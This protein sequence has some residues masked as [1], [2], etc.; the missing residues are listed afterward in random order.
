MSTLL[1]K[2]RAMGASGKAAPNW[3][4]FRNG[5]GPSK[6][7][8]RV[9]ALPR[10]QLSP[11]EEHAAEL[12]TYLRRPGGTMSLRPIQA[13]A[14]EEAYAASGLLALIGVGFGKGLL[15]L[16]L[17]TAWGATNAALLVPPKLKVKLWDLEYPEY[18]KHWRIPNLVGHPIQYTDTKAVLHV[19]SYSDLSSAKRADILERIAP[20]AVICD[21]GHSLRHSSAARTKRFK[22]FF[23]EARRR[24][25]V[26][27]AV[28]SGSLTSGSI[29]D[30]AHLADI[31][32]GDGSPLPR[33]WNEVQ[34]WAYALDASDFPSPGGELCRLC[35]PGEGVRSGF[36][37]RLVETPGVVATT[38]ND[39]GMSLVFDRRELTT[40]KVVTDALEKL[41]A[42]WVR[43]DGTPLREA[44]EV[45]GASRQLACGFYY[46]TIYPRNEP[47]ALRR[48]WIDAR[49]NYYSEVRDRLTHSIKG[50][51]SYLLLWQAADSGKWKSEHFEAWKAIHE[52][53][54]PDT[55]TVWLD[56]FLV[57]AAIE[58]ALEKPGIVW[59]ESEAVRAAEEIALG[60]GIPVYAGGD[61]DTR[62]LHA[63]D[64]SR[65]VV[66]S[67]KAFKEGENLQ[68]FN[69]SLITTPPASGAL[70][71]QVIGRTHRSG[72]T[73]DEVTV[74]FFLHTPEL[75][76]ALK[77]AREKAKA[78][79]E[80]T[81]NFQKLSVGAWLF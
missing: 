44:I 51:D 65:S 5:P 78:I 73:A 81:G 22:R 46:R 57:N 17:P 47:P 77:D 36:R 18:S 61:A 23:R 6:D 13:A 76:S 63:E 53:V 10:R 34:S 58:W 62:R 27:C 66:C 69:R 2:L 25:R 21:E 79:Q 19:V 28:L 31:C 68:A 56:K 59:V 50:Q 64:G 67:I 26:A 9:F 16:L 8:E 3:G 24:N 49:R 72:Q 35:E 70:L 54:K 1:E 45:Y 41:R 11:T 4:A 55:E 52:A 38:T 43:P 30:F 15:S 60:A 7:F 71:E 14:L 40:P 32:L 75:V 12:T 39:P 29:N 48:E 20:D 80:T 37:R 33:D 74:D 42:E